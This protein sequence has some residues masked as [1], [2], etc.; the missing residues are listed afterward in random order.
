[1]TS[2]SN[3]ELISAFSSF[4]FSN[5]ITVF[6]AL[7]EEHGKQMSYMCVA[8]RN[9]QGDSVRS[10]LWSGVS[11]TSHM[12]PWLPGDSPSWAQHVPLAG[13]QS[14]VGSPVFHQI[15]CRGAPYIVT[16]QACRAQ[17]FPSKTDFL[18]DQGV[19]PLTREPEFWLSIFIKIYIH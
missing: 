8:L 7:K 16:A 3:A 10:S 18:T 13:T 6:S 11:L 12:A 4:P 17:S 19:L 5:K 9:S 14:P 2:F 15:P 1:M